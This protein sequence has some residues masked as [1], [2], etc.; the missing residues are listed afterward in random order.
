MKTKDTAGIPTGDYCY[1]RDRKDDTKRIPCPYWSEVRPTIND[2]SKKGGIR[3]TP[4]CGH[5]AFIG[6]SDD[7]LQKEDRFGLLWDMVKECGI[8]PRPRKS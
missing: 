6:K 7:D 4:G 3:C 2:P 5:C 8:K 1:S